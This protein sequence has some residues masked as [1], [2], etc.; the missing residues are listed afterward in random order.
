M[1]IKQF[2]L[3]I[4]FSLFTFIGIQ[5]SAQYNLNQIDRAPTYSGTSSAGYVPY[6]I[7]GKVKKA[8]LA[9]VQYI[10]RPYKVYTALLSQDS[11][12]KAPTAVVLENTLGG[13]VTYAKTDTG[14]YTAT[15]TG[16]FTTAK[17]AF[18]FTG[19]DG[20]YWAIRTSAN[21]ITL[22]TRGSDGS[23]ADLKL[24]STP[25]EFRVYY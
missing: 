12:H 25:I 6:F 15:L 9:Q 14:T 3:F 8:T 16:A 22:Y 13:T 24:S 5:S 21:V 18:F 7:G 10:V 23:E 20:E 19:Y 17:T 2:K 4:L 1:S 11:A